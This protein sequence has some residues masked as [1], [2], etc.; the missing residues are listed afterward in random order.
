MIFFVIDAKP[1]GMSSGLISKQRITSYANKQRSNPYLARLDSQGFG[2]QPFDD[3]GIQTNIEN[4]KY[5]LQIVLPALKKVI[6]IIVQGS[7]F[8]SNLRTKYWIQYGRDENLL[9]T[10]KILVSCC[11]CF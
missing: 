8:H 7:K 3:A 4:A 10:Y 9:T 2:W 5:W 6:Y 1:L 11:S